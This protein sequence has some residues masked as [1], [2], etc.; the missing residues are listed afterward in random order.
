MI[1]LDPL[2]TPPASV[3]VDCTAVP[4]IGITATD[5]CD[6]DVT[7]RLK[8]KPNTRLLSD[9]YTLTRP[10]KAVDNCGNEAT[11]SQNHHRSGCELTRY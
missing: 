5:N 2:L 10:W 8:V 6:P 1:K 11:A 7:L 4:G 9:A 3:T